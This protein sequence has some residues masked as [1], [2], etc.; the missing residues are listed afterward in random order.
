MVYVLLALVFTATIVQYSRNYGRLLVGPLYDDVV[1]LNEGLEYAQMAQT[2]G[3]WAL[4][5]RALANPPHSPFA[6]AV[7]SVSF[8]LLGPV[9]W[10]PYAV[11]GLA[12]L[13]VVLAADRLLA[14]LPAHA[15]LAGA[16]FVLTFPIVGTLPYHFRPDAA[17]G[18]VTGFGVVMM[19]R[20]SPRWAP[21]RQQ[22]W[23]GLCFALAL[24]IKTSVLPLT[25][26]MFGSSWLLSLVAGRRTD[27]VAVSGA[28]LERRHRERGTWAAI[29]PYLLPV[30][31]VAGPYYLLAGRRVLRYIYDQALGQNRQ[32][33]VMNRDWASLA[34][35]VWDGEGGRLM[36]GHHGYLVLGIACLS[37]VVYGWR[38]RDQ[39]FDRVRTRLVL[40]TCGAI[41]LAWLPPTLSRYGN[42]FTGATFAAL[43]LF[44]GVLLLRSLFLLDWAAPRRGMRGA[45]GTAL[46]W[47]AV[48]ASLLV[49]RGPAGL[50]VRTTEWVVIDNRVER[51]V[52]RAIVDD[53]VGRHAAVFVTSAAD[54]NADL[55][56]FRALVDQVQMRFLGPPFSSDLEDYRQLIGGSDYVVTG[57]AGA[58][59]ENRQLPFYA[60]Q[61]ALVTELRSDP[62]FELLAT[63]PAHEGLNVYVFRR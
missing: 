9:Q 15:R 29:W 2:R 43:W 50:G 4:A 54:L 34:R 3:P 35:F 36:L 37:G 56:R 55:L 8:L 49:F 59:R 7:A 33:W 61:D 20:C 5:E 40:A 11:M 52:Y 13:A 19:L 26:F 21:R 31:L 17:A 44:G 6:T 22:Y 48:A 46:G 30:L 63:V 39:E 25:L 62:E 38:R 51:A 12:V 27:L 32:L 18:L 14:G 1:Y 47:G 10:A 41:F 60:L 16:L 28:L 53:A 42:P 45:L 58:F 23:T 24:V 57:D